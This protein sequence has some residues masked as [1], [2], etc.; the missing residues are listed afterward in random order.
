MSPSP[1][2]LITGA[3]NGIGAATALMLAGGGYRILATD[4]DE[5]GLNHLSERIREAGGEVSAAPGDV[6]SS[7]DLSA[8][9]EQGL[10][11]WERLD[12]VVTCAGINAYHDA[13]SMTEDEWDNVFG[14]DL[15]GAWLTCR[16]ALPSLLRSDRAAIVNVSSIHARQTTSGMFPY[17][18]AKAGVEGLTRSLALDYGPRG[19]RVNAVAPGWTRTHLVD[20]WLAL[21]ENPE[22]ALRAV[23]AAHPLGHFAEPDDIA[24]AITFLLSPAARAVTGATLV[25]DCGLTARFAQ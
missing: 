17:A 24:A 22:Q 10:T 14:V 21:Q 16:A 5:N 4:L 19:V 6:R 12:A 3:A 20:E 2:V 8:L 23:N 9:V 11:R 18:A 15:K 7:A 1:V 13:V 25:V